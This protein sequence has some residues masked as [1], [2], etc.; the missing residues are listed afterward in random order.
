MTVRQTARGIGLR[1]LVLLAAI[2]IGGI[3][4]V[5]NLVGAVVHLMVWVVVGIIVFALVGFA[6]VRLRR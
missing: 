1:A 4:L 5:S 3:W 2:V 6:M